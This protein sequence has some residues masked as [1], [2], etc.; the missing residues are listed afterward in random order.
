MDTV[1]HECATALL[2]MTV[3]NKEKKEI[4]APIGKA[5]EENGLLLQAAGVTT[6][7]TDKICEFIKKEGGWATPT[8]GCGGGYVLAFSD[9]QKHLKKMEAKVKKKGWPCYV[10]RVG[11]DGIKIDQLTRF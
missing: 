11:G 3:K 4:Y 2:D 9:T 6:K 5:V 8:G 7:K 10:T 1:S